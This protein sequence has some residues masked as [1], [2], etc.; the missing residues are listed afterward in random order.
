MWFHE[1]LARW[2]TLNEASAQLLFILFVSSGLGMCDR[3]N[4]VTCNLTD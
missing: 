4:F 2:H 1:Q 3:L